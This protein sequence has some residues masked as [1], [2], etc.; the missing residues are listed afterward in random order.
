MD[1]S[2]KFAEDY[3]ALTTGSGFVEFENWTT[4][5]LTGED[6]QPFLHNMCT[7]DVRRLE[8]GDHCEAYLTDVKGKIIGHVFIFAQ[9]DCLLLLT[10]PEQ[11]E[12]I[13][14]HLD[15]YIIREDVQLH[16]HTSTSSWLLVVGATAGDAIKNLPCF[17]AQSQLFWP[18][19]YLLQCEIGNKHDIIQQL[20]AAQTRACG[21]EALTTIR[22]ES[23]LP[24][25][26]VDF[27]EVNLPQEINRDAQAI[28]FTKGC[29][30]GQETIA[31]IDALGHVNQKVVLL[32]FA[33]EQVPPVGLELLMA[34]KVVGSVTSS[35]WSPRCQAPLALAMLRRGAND[36]GTQ[37]D[38]ALGVATV[39]EP[40][41]K[42][43]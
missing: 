40:L 41:A 24:L 6:R 25:M 42:G 15:R 23:Q 11:A 36:L 17:V 26:G 19:S 33:G 5:T 38:S 13:I 12:A 37:L 4:V 35:G 18:E 9:A 2:D 43:H 14:T 34:E 1:S 8:L 22:I 20:Q 10:V 27:A 16:D 32:E 28:S 31:R 21:I 7:N 3:A 30:L 29:Y 39:R